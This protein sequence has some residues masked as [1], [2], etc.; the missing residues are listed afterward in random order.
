MAKSIYDDRKGVED[1]KLKGDQVKKVLDRVRD[2]F[3]SSKISPG[4]AIG[5]VTAESIGEPGTQMTLNVFHFAGVAEVA[6]TLGLPRL[7]ELLDAR[8]EPSTPRI[9]VHLDK[10]IAKD[11]VKVKKVAATIKETK[12]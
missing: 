7:I 6:V 9:E 10:E 12:L 2:S 1:N 8:K 3:E 4:E 11:P 5:I